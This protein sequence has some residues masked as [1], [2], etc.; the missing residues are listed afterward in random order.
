MF[1]NKPEHAETVLLNA[2]HAYALLATASYRSTRMQCSC[3]IT[4]YYV[5]A[6]DHVCAKSAELVHIEVK[7]LTERVYCVQW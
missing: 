5:I 6:T 4:C 3:G 2:M 1:V 7:K